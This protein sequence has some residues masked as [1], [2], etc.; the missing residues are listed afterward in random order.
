MINKPIEFISLRELGIGKTVEKRV[1][2]LEIQVDHHSALFES[3]RGTRARAHEVLHER[4][5]KQDEVLG[6][7]NKRLLRIERAIYMGMGALA[8]VDILLKVIG[9]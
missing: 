8:A 9:R 2:H 3:E 5:T 4:L 6:D 1:E 7:Q